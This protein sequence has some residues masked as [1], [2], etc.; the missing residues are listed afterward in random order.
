MFPTISGRQQLFGKDKFWEK[1]RHTEL[2]MC[3]SISVLCLVIS[4]S[5]IF[6]LVC[7][8]KYAET[9]QM[10]KMFYD[11]TQQYHARLFL[12]VLPA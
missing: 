12:F 11:K 7:H 9:F 3:I 8:M 4:D 6:L 5:R 2:H 10:N 1:S